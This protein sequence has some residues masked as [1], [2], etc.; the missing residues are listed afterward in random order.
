MG[1]KMVEYIETDAGRRL[2]LIESGDW[3]LQFEEKIITSGRCAALLPCVLYNSMGKRRLQFDTTG[4]VSL[5]DYGICELDQ[6]LNLLYMVPLMILEAEDWLLR[7]EKFSLTEEGVYMNTSTGEVRL[8]YGF[9]GRGDFRGQYTEL[10]EAAASW[11]YIAGLRAAANQIMEK[12]KLGNPDMKMLL[13]IVE[14]VR[15]E[16]NLIQPRRS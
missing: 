11:D 12:I 3:V 2:A 8:I 15:R 1:V 13:R 4:Y 7:A 10:L 9:R 14:G 16:W 5:K 6:A